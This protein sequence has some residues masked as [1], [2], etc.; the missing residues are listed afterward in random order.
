[1]FISPSGI[2]DCCNQAN[3]CA[4]IN[5]ST[6]PDQCVT[7]PQTPPPTP[8]APVTP[9]PTPATTMPPTTS[10]A[11]ASKS[12]K[13]SKT[14]KSGKASKGSKA[15]QSVSMNLYARESESMSFYF[16]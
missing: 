6:L 9:S 14:G 1:M 12:G 7:T 2:I 11:T 15:Y 3:E 5:E 8:P 16:N 10:G 13:K 4:G